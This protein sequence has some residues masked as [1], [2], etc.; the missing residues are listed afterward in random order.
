MR[1]N[2]LLLASIALAVLLA[3]GA[4]LSG[5]PKPVGAAEPRGILDAGCPANDLPEQGVVD[6]P[7]VVEGGPPMGADVH[8]NK[9]WGAN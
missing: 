6:L 4:V 9:N 7:G 1:T 2:I 8:S 5:T 3:C